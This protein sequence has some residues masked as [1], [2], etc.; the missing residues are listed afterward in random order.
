MLH[1]IAR[2]VGVA[3]AWSDSFI[4]GTKNWSAYHIG[5]SA[6]AG[7]L[8]DAPCSCPLRATVYTKPHRRLVI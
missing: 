4:L 3:D 6:W 7:E 8:W 5:M 1:R 2:R